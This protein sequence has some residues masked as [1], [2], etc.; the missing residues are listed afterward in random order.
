MCMAEDSINEGFWGD[1]YDE[2]ENDTYY[3]IA[4]PH[5]WCVQ[6]GPHFESECHSVKMIQEWEAYERKVNSWWYRLSEY[7]KSRFWPDKCFDC[8][9][10]FGRH[11]GCLPF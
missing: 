6:C 5:D 9:K 10:R 4:C 2:W 7:M 1:E 3:S 11:D 8:G